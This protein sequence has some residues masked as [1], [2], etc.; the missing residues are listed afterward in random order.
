MLN[1]V[2]AKLQQLSVLGPPA[3]IGLGKGI[4]GTR[5]I[6]FRLIKLSYKFSVTL[7]KKRYFIAMVNLN[8][9]YSSK[10]ISSFLILS[11]TFVSMIQFRDA[12]SHRI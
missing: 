4:V 2:I 11:F 7:N 9:T 12:T 10:Y 8:N 5:L 3:P 6:F 1:S